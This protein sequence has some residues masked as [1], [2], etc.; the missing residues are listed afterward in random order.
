M[1]KLDP[2]LLDEIAV[3]EVDAILAGL[4]DPELNTKPAFLARVRAFLKEND[5]V[6][7]PE[8]TKEVEEEVRKIPT[9]S[10][11]EGDVVEI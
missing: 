2:K 11:I 3:L 9:F 8:V 1:A 5:L 10:V 4:R 6:T 7:T